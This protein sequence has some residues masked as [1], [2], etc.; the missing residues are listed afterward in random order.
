MPFL[1]GSI[2]IEVYTDSAQTAFP[3]EL[4]PHIKKTLAS[5]TIT[6]VQTTVVSLAASGSQTISFNGVAAPTR[7]YIYSNVASVLV[8]MNGLGNITLMAAEPGYIPFAV[9]SMVLTNNSS[10]DATTVT[11]VL[12]Q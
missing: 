4:V 6:K 12:I 3:L 1:T 7:F 5:S 9:T 2:E 11:V 8:N 10:S